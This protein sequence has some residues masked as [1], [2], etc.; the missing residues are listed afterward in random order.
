MFP[1]W[2]KS[3][4]DIPRLVYFLAML[5]TSL[6]FASTS[7]FLARLNFRKRP[8]I[9]LVCS[10]ISSADIPQRVLIT[11]A[12][13]WA[14]SGRRVFRRCFLSYS[15]LRLISSSSRENSI[16]LLVVFSAIEITKPQEDI[17]PTLFLGLREYF[18]RWAIRPKRLSTDSFFTFI[19]SL[20]MSSRLASFSNKRLIT[21]RVSFREKGVRYTA[22]QSAFSVASIFL[23]KVISSSRLST[24][25]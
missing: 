20:M 3:R 24:I 12:F 6:K 2:I 21:F 7:F 1:S 4:K 14:S 19:S 15:S 11:A 17:N 8:R 5:T 25:G 22:S 13:L 9:I 18:R 16:N 10:F 23:A